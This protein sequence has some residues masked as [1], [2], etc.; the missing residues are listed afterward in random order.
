MA[1]RRGVEAGHAR[2]GRSLTDAG[3]RQTLKRARD[4]FAELLLEDVIH[5]L[6]DPTVRQ[7]LQGLRV[8][9]LLDYC[10]PALEKRGYLA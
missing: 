10:R 2:L 9:G 4:K 3:V 7:L 6:E 5:S 8:L 1:R